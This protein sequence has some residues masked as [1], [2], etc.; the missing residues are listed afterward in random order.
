MQITQLLFAPQRTII[1]YRLSIHRNLG[2][3]N[4]PSTLSECAMEIAGQI[5]SVG[6]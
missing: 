2:V 4:A 3:D 1:I 6:K 5:G